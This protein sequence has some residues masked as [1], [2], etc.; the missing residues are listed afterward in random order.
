MR[1]VAA[2]LRDARGR[3]LLARRPAGKVH[4]GLWEFPGGKVEA[5]EEGLAALSRE[6]DEE[7]G[8]EV[9]AARPLLA[10]PHED[11]VLDVW[12][13]PAF[14]GRPHAREG[15]AFAWIDPARVDAASM[16][17]ADRPVLT[18]LRLPD[19]YLVTPD[20]DGAGEDAFLDTLGRALA[21]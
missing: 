12:E 18:A 6:L 19:R 9:L 17:P 15:Q 1:V 14:A 10:I 16:P 20:V 2:V 5:G 3:V 11:I 4:A 13:V 21:N 7:L 8:I